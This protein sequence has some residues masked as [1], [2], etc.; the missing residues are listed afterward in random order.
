MLLCTTA[1]HQI[2]R[3]STSLRAVRIARASSASGSLMELTSQ[4]A[5]VARKR[6]QKQQPKALVE[7][8]SL[9][10]LMEQLDREAKTN[11]TRD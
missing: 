11:G 10:F 6:S 5:S 7:E 9:T 4:S 8:L 3:R 1:P 2:Q